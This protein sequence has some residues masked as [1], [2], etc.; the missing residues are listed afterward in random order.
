MAKLVADHAPS[1]IRGSAFGIFNVAIGLAL[2][3]ASVVAG[4]LWDKLGSEATFFAGAGFAL[5]ALMMFVFRLD[6]REA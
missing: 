2:L 3:I 1:D 5:T 4:L 6:R